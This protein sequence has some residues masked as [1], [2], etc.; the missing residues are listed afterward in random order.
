MI[1]K[2][3]FQAIV[4]KV[5]R[6]DEQRELV[7]RK[8]RDVLK[9][10]K[11]VIYAL[12]RDDVSGAKKALGLLKKAVQQINTLVGGSGKLK[13]S[14][15]AKIAIQEYVEALVYYDF[16]TQGRV[17]DYSPEMLDEDYYLLG[18]C[19]VSGELVRKAVN[20]GI[21]GKYKEV[22]KIKNLVSDIYGLFLLLNLRNSDLRKS[23]DSIKWGLKKLEDLVL[24]LKLKGKLQ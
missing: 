6:F 13:Y 20:D 1:H 2:K 9:L 12:H 7:I 4:A 5:H 15:S 16:F 8:S 18:L 21:K 14:G 24:E 22:L 3:K 10:S 11:Q 17:P 19:D 23:F